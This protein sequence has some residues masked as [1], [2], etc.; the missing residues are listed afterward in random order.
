MSCT[1]TCTCNKSNNL[2]SELVSFCQKE[3]FKGYV[4]DAV[5]TQMFWNNFWEHNRI[6][7]RVD[8]HLL[9]KVPGMVRENVTSNLDSKLAGLIATELAKQLPTYLNQN[10]QMRQILEDH[11][12]LLNQ[13]LETIA[14]DHLLKIVNEDNYHLVNKAY[15]DAFEARTKAAISEFDKH[16]NSAIDMFDRNGRNAITEMNR[17][18]NETLS[19]F[20]Q[21]TQKLD[22]NERR[23]GKLE[24]HA[25]N[26]MWTFGFTTT[27]LSGITIFLL[28]K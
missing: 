9:S 16:A 24:N 18:C 22:D 14:H 2:E 10:V 17:N 3:I 12:K 8:N 27:I 7:S 4:R 11:A 13:N 28:L 1:H 21:L 26:M 23:F 25:S 19:N 5:N 20:T 6:E 15:F